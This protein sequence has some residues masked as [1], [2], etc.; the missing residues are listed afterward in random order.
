[1]PLLDGIGLELGSDSL[2]KLFWIVKPQTCT[3][4]DRINFFEVD[5]DCC[6]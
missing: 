5:C 4:A 6:F 1:M 2:L 3:R